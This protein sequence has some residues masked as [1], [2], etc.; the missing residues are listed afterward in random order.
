[1]ADTKWSWRYRAV[2]SNSLSS[3]Q[4]RDLW[5]LCKEQFGADL[6]PIQRWDTSFVKRRLNPKSFVPVYK[7]TRIKVH[8]KHQED[9]VMF[10][11][12]YNPQD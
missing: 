2:I 8:F 4:M 6:D 5:Q 12:T 9:L 1:M 3:A 10:K 11:L 7:Y